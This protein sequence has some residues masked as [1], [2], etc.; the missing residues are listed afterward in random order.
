MIFSDKEMMELGIKHLTNIHNVRPLIRTL[1]YALDILQTEEA[2]T[3]EEYKHTH[4]H[5][6]TIA[7]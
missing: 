6:Q 2:F 7:K 3:V 5:T 4:T 1:K